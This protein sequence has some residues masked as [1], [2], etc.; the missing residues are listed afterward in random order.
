MTML[1]RVL[2]RPSA[3][4]DAR[5]CKEQVLE[6]KMAL[7]FDVG[8]L[9]DGA[10]C[11]VDQVANHFQISAR[12]VFR[13]IERGHLKSLKVLRRRLIPKNEL[14]RFV[15]ELSQPLPQDGLNAHNQTELNHE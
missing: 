1:G 4:G 5:V 3:S 10:M 9:P 2:V 12:S 15:S 13:L 8:C 14:E 11:T 7:D 6:P